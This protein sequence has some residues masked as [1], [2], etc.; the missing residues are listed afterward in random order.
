MADLS[1][2]NLPILS[3]KNWSR[4]STQMRVLFRVQGVSSVIEGVKSAI[5]IHGTEDQKE[6]FKK[7]DDKVLL[8]I[9]QCVDDTHFVKIQN[10]NIAKEAWNILVRCHAGGEKIK[11]VRLQTL[12]RQYELLQM[13]DGDKEV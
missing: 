11:K 7:K 5:E 10:A 13:E 1:A 8:I 6:E 3:K 12:R 4:W 9:H 2:T